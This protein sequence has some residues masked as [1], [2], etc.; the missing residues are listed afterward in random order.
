MTDPKRFSSLQARAA[1]LGVS[2]V[3]IRNDLERWAFVVTVGPVTQE[4]ASLD[5]VEQW[6]TTLSEEARP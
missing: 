5:D 4:L 1:L 3:A 6:L 2:L